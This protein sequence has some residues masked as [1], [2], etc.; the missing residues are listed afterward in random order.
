MIFSMR[1]CLLSAGRGSPGLGSHGPPELLLASLL[2]AAFQ[3]LT[4][5]AEEGC[6]NRTQ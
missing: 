3:R 5:E 4:W 2:H 6:R 1:I